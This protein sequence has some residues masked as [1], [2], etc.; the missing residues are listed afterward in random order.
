MRCACRASDGPNHLGLCAPQSKLTGH[1]GSRLG[2]ALIKVRP[3]P[4]LLPCASTAIISCKTLLLPCVSTLFMAKT[5]P[6]WLG[7]WQG[8]CASYASLCIHPHASL[9]HLMHLMHPF[10][11]APP[12][13]PRTRTWPGVS[14]ASSPPPSA[15]TPS[16]GRPCFSRCAPYTSGTQVAHRA[17]S[18]TWPVLHLCAPCYSRCV[19]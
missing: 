12:V 9:M 15:T 4:L 13:P 19:W 11:S 2:W 8:P 3:L 16:S 6:D 17:P 18:A 5:V 7:A 1:A 14:A 10:V